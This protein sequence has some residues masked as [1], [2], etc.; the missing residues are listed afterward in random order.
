MQAKRGG[1]TP[2]GWTDVRPGLL[3]ALAES[4]PELEWIDRDLELGDGRRVDL[5]GVD[6]GGRAT[7]LLLVGDDEVA[8]LLAALDAHAWFAQ[9]RSLLGSHFGHAR[10]DPERAARVLLVAERFSD[11]LLAR[12]AGLDPAVVQALEL[13]RVESQRGLRSYLVPARPA[14]FGP[15]AEDPTGARALLRGLAPESAAQAERLLRRLGRADDELVLAA[16]GAGVRCTLGGAALCG[17]QA[18]RGQLLGWVGNA[19]PQPLALPADGEAWIEDVLRE[20]RRLLPVAP[21]PVQRAAGAREPE[22]PDPFDPLAP[23][24]S[25]EEI[26]AFQEP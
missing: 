15:V 22:G 10:L 16:D 4:L 2:E 17:L 5:V 18:R 19:T 23:L 1:L 11:I 6:D 26:A 3:A 25:S 9:H 8:A 12:L 14:P 7:A 13:R 24:L 21:G 20:L